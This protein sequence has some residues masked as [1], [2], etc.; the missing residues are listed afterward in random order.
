MSKIIYYLFWMFAYLGFCFL[1]D[2]IFEDKF[3]GTFWESVIRAFTFLI[4]LV[5][6]NLS[7][8]KGW[9]S[10]SKVIGIFKRKK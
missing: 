9:S 4:A 7:E 8:K 1:L 2:I 10:W 5:F 3:T 6:I